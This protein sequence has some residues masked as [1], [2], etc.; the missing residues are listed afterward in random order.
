MA[1]KYRRH[2]GWFDFEF[3]YEDAQGDEVTLECEGYYVG[4]FPDTHYCPGEPPDVDIGRV[5]VVGGDNGKDVFDSLPESVKQAIEDKVYELGEKRERE[6]REYGPE[7][8][9]LD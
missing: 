1:T 3:S 4:G 7:W 6:A 5:T 8:D 2:P 9:D